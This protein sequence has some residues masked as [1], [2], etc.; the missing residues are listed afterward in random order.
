MYADTDN[1]D[2]LRR[3]YQAQN[4]IPGYRSLKETTTIIGTWDDHDYGLNDGGA[5]FKLR[6]QSQ[7]QFLTFMGVSKNDERRA[8]NGI[9]TTHNFADMRVKIIVLDTRYFR[10]PLTPDNSS[11]KRYKPGAEGTVLG[12]VQWA[13]LEKELKESK[14]ILNIIVSSIQLLSEDHGFETWGNFPKER[15]KFIDLIATSGAKGVLVLSGDRH[16][17]EFS[18]YKS[19]ELDFP[20]IDFTSSGLTHSYSSFTSESN[21]YRVGEVVATESFGLVQ[22]YLDQQKVVM[23]IIGDGGSVLGQLEQSY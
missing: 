11:N 16:I 23:K 10:S 22:C 13:W 15:K 4:E 5:D 17:S 12:D 6:A 1:M 3:I 21:P 8:R 20:L 14:A 19:Q 2:S 7:D 9:Y 18:V